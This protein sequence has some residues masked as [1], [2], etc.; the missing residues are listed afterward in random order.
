MAGNS[1]PNINSYSFSKS[2]AYAVR[3]CFYL[4]EYLVLWAWSV[5]INGI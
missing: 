5:I 4:Q 1:E 2:S 3:S